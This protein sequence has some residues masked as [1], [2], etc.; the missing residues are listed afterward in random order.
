MEIKMETTL[1]KRGQTVVP[2][3]IRKRYNLQ[4]GDKLVWIDD[5]QTVKVIFT[6]SDIVKALR[7]SGK[8]HKLTERLLAER[9]AEYKHEKVRS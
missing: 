9:R 6:Q 1:T 8:G 5:G 4:E 2:A 7:G 3:E